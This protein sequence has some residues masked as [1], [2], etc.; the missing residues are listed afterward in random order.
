[1]RLTLYS[2][3]SLRVLIYLG[4]HPDRL[5]SVAEVSEAYGVSQNHIVKVVHNL[6]KL[7]FVKTTRG[8]GG[9]I[10]LAGDPAA[11]N[12]GQVVR[13]TEPATTLV[14]CFDAA[15]N[16]C[17]LAPCC[18]LKSVLAAAQEAFYAVL[19]RYTLADVIRKPEAMRPLLQLTVG[20]KR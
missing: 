6:A 15:S 1:M 5:A 14:E 10:K 16:T 8:R 9:G 19:D 12:L 13:Q 4:L 7:G 18:G 20:G 17:R 3:Y 11:L 2:D